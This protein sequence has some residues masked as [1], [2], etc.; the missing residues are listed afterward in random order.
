MITRPAILFL[1]HRIPYPPNK[2][3]KIRTFNQ[4]R[5]F[6]QFFDI[7]LVALVDAPDD[8]ERLAEYREKLET[9]CRSVHLFRLE[10]R[11]AK[12]RGIWSIA[13][14]G[15]ISQG[16]FFLKAAA[17]RVCDLMTEEAYKAVFCFSSPTAEYV[18]RCIDKMPPGK[19]RPR[20]IMD[21]CDVDSEKWR[22]Y[23][24]TCAFPMNLVYRIEARRLNRFEAKVHNRFDAS[25]FVSDQEANLFRSRVSAYGDIIVVT[26]G[27][28]H[29]YFSPDHSESAAEDSDKPLVLMFPGAMDYHANA[30]AVT[31]FCESVLPQLA[32]VGRR[33]RFDIVGKNPIPS[34]SALA[35]MKIHSNI[36]VQVTGFVEDIRP[37]YSAADIVVVPLRIARGIQ[38]KVLEAMAMARPVIAS[39][40]AADGIGAED[41][42]HLITAQTSQEFAQHIAAWGRDKDASHK[43]GRTARQFVEE[44]F[45]WD[46]CL[47]DLVPMIHRK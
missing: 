10:T 42:R 12:L 2:G 3:D 45:S 20:L 32:D 18:L 29:R 25:V 39:P 22:Q 9:C 23:A 43:I 30:D 35:D 21:F 14:G 4:V 15:S 5:F 36:Q 34:V 40:S 19:A 6:S 16:Y 28:D 47:K 24:E 41:G 13:R 27:V 7:D 31:W 17:G 26:N 37:Y 46:A 1:A 44:R 8:M 38:N 11:T 33:I